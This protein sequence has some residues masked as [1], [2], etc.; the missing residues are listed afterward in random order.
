[1]RTKKLVPVAHAYNPSYTGSRD[2]EDGCL[3]PEQADSS[4]DLTWKTLNPHTKNT[5]LVEWF[6]C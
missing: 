2:Q 6:K 1:M 5:E 3:K 4:R